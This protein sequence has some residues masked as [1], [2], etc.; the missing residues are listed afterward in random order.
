MKAQLESQQP[1]REEAN[2]L[3]NQALRVLKITDENAVRDNFAD[4]D[5]RWNTLL[6]L[7]VQSES[8]NYSDEE[9][10]PTSATGAIGLL[11]EELREMQNALLNI[12]VVVETEDDLY[13]Y[14]EKLQVCVY[15]LM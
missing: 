11:A 5:D 15:N 13:N 7:V 10:S 8:A 9:T 3:L 6:S 1:L 12:S 2:I 4:F 14:L